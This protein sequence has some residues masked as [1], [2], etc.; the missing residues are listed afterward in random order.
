MY[1]TSLSAWTGPRLTQSP[2][3]R[4]EGNGAEGPGVFPPLT[5]LQDAC[6]VP[7]AAFCQAAGCRDRGPTGHHHN[8]NQ[9][10]W[11]SVEAS[12]GGLGT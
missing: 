9:P 8:K 5:K 6:P 1:C 4:A 3:L 10:G 2:P 11:R 7:C 12:R